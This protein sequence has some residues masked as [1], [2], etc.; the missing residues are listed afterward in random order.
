MFASGGVLLALEIV[1]SRVLAPT[2]GNSIYVWGSL[3]GVFL[4]ALSVGYWVG[5]QVADRYPRY[6]IFCGLVLL[7]GL[8]VA[9]IPAV[10]PWLL[11]RIALANVGPRVGPL[12]AAT[13][14]FFPASL[15]MGTVSPFAVRLGTRTVQ[16]VGNTA[17]RL[18]ALSTLGSIVGCLAAA[19]W[20]LSILG[21]REII[22]VLGLVEMGMAAV[23]FAA[24][25]RVAGA[26]ATTA[27][28][29]VAAILIPRVA[30]AD[31]PGLVY[32]RATV[33]HRITVS[34]EGGVRYLKLDNYWQSAMDLQD[35]NRTVFR[36]ADYMHVGMLFVPD[37]ER[38]LLIGVGGGTIP[39]Q[40][41]RDYPGVHMDMVDID[42]QVI[43]VARRYFHVPVGGRLRAFAEDGRQF[44]RRASGR[45]DQVLMDAY[46]RDTLPFHLATREFFQE[47]RGVLTSRGVFVMN[48]IG[49]L[50]GPESRLFRSVYRTLREVFPAV[51]VFPV[52]FGPWGG[53]EALRNIIVLATQEPL[54]PPGAVRARYARVRDRIRIPGFEAVVRDLYT[55]PIPTQDVPVLSDNF[56]PVDDLIHAR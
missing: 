49:A 26:V 31:P 22:L 25:R 2:F 14:L 18:Y 3:I 36:Y 12:L 56:A 32:A 10:S 55:R 4:T 38:V 47:V 42:P 20:L 54:E 34:D 35:P 50:A 30:S 23:G 43:E 7:A 40:Y 8:L 53:E 48:V 28:M 27:A 29:V 9:P 17:G 52:E 6:D 16:T 5:G 13:L 51:Y 33:Y 15:V 45:Y 24:A 41:L 21:V 19:F 44:V 1:A 46:L 37:P 11:E 39:K